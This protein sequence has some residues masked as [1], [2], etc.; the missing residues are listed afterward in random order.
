MKLPRPQILGFSGLTIGDFKTPDEALAVADQLLAQNREAYG[1]TLATHPPQPGPIPLLDCFFFVKSEGLQRTKFS[2]D[3]QKIDR[4]SQDPKALTGVAPLAIE[5]M[6]PNSLKKEGDDSIVL[7]APS[8]AMFWGKAQDLKKKIN[9]HRGQ[10][11]RSQE[12]SAKLMLKAR[13]GDS[14]ASKSYE[15]FSKMLLT[16]LDVIAALQVQKAEADLMTPQSNDADL[17]KGAET[18]DEALGVAKNHLSGAKDCYAE[19][20]TKV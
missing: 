1:H 18:L 8:W 10:H 16:L 17:K 6:P 9:A 19:Y 3:N 15:S 14:E 2:G 13:G 7:A 5:M 11:S 4:R 20:K 12:L